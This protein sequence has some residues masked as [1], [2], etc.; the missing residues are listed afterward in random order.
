MMQRKLVT[1]FLLLLL[2]GTALLVPSCHKD[3]FNWKPEAMLVTKPDSGLTTQIFDFLV[4]I[5]NLPTSQREF[6]VRWDFNGDSLW[7]DSFTAL[8]SVKHR[9]YQKG[10]HQV[11]AEILTEDG[12]RIA[13][14][15]DIR[16]SQGFSAPHAAFSIDPPESHY[17]TNFTFNADSTFDDEDLFSSLLFNWDFE[18]DGVW[19]TGISSSPV[20]RH[21]YRKA[22]NYKVRL[23]AMDPTRR[24]STVIRTLVVTLH[25]DGIQ[26][27]FTWSPAEA[28]VKDTFILDATLTKDTTGSN[29]VF[30]YTWDVKS[31]VTYGPF[32]DPRFAHVFWFAGAQQISLTATDQ[33]GLSN[34]ITKEFYVGKENKPPRPAIQ[35]STPYG[36]I[37]TNFFL[38]SWYS[39]DDVTPPS[40]MLV[41]WD[42]EGDGNWDT[43]WSYDK[44]LFHQFAQAG[45]YWITLE[46]E[47]GGGARAIAKTRV[48]VSPYSSPTGFILDRRDGKYYGTVKIGDQWWMSDNLD[49]RTNPKM[50]IP[51][52]QICFAESNGLCDLYGSLY[53]AERAVGYTEAGNN[54][55]PEG[56]RMPTRADWLKL[57]EQVPPVNGR[58]AML[59]GGSLGF[60]AK[61]TGYADFAF[62]YDSFGRIVDT[63]YHFYDM[64]KKV[65]FLSLTSR[66]FFEEHQAHFYMGVQNDFDGV[67]FRWGNLN[68]YFYARCVKDE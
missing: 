6:Y 58:D 11:K 66:N 1:G 52:L 27:D 36:N 24:V 8:P 38:S 55:C 9:F 21:T 22:G 65:Q 62:K 15:R 41:R 32:D 7:D 51:M 18:D 29:R 53:Q 45:E 35:I 48:L 60:N 40:E 50:K 49:Y 61:Y 10:V 25:D 68:G 57:A 59:V 16:I 12:Q 33:S 42:F 67:D 3:P 31:E 30:S 4:D 46:A 47:D 19:D 2:T 5:T 26:P 17:L 43:G 44:I 56:W 34:K 39:L 28:T 37:A 23:S 63:L 13:V 20:A 54:M 64:T 14:S